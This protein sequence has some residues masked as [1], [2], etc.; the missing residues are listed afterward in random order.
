MA[1]TQSCWRREIWDFLLPV[2]LASF[3]VGVVVLAY[4]GYS[5]VRSILFITGVLG[6]LGDYFS[7]KVGLKWKRE[8]MMIPAWLLM[9]IAGEEIAL[10]VIKGLGFGLLIVGLLYSLPL[11]CLLTLTLCFFTFWNCFALS[12]ERK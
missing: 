10:I 5:F 4:G 1:G 11:L 6:N 7:T 8:E 2:L 9:K 3:L 12:L